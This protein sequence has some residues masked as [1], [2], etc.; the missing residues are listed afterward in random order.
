MKAPLYLEQLLLKHPC[1][2]GC[3]PSNLRHL[4]DFRLKAMNKN[5]QIVLKAAAIIGTK[6]DLGFLDY[7]VDDIDYDLRNAHGIT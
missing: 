2:V 1:I 4:M 6:I 7:M 3:F 5:S